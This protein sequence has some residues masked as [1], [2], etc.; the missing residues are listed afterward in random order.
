MNAMRQ[1]AARPPR[2]GEP[3]R[4][5]AA[6]RAPAASVPI[7]APATA[8]CACGG[9]CP[10]CRSQANTLSVSRPGDAGEAQARHIADRVGRGESVA[11]ALRP[12]S[13]AAG[14]AR[15]GVGGGPSRLGGAVAQTLQASRGGGQPLNPALGTS[16]GRQF[17]ADFG[18]VRVHADG[19]AAALSDRLHA[20]AFTVGRDVYF[21]RGRYQPQTPEGRHLLAHELT[22]VVQQ[23]QG[24]ER[25][26]RDLEGGG[27]ELAEEPEQAEQA[28][29]GV[30]TGDAVEQRAGCNGAR[31][32]HL[33]IHNEFPNLEFTVPTGC[34]A[35]LTF[36]ALWVPVGQGVDCC[37]GADTYRVTRHGGTPRSLPV[38]ANICGD[39]DRHPR[40]IG[41]LTMRGGHHVLRIQVDRSG[42]EGISMELDINVRIR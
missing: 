19:E 35:T 31:D 11:G 27:G 22:H 2:S 33:M 28:D 30:G 1:G 26:Q 14:I 37:T 24:D 29:V 36:S 10:Q 32:F 12:G 40:G 20:K 15:D 5:M 21:N 9:T 13:V 41:H 8:S 17:G 34:T 39:D 4:P 25:V 3:R 6:S 7:P 42:C 23:G 16:L 18:A 38:G